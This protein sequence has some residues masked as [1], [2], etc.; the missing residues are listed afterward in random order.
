MYDVFPVFRSF[1][2]HISVLRSESSL[3]SNILS[4]F[5]DRPIDFSL[6]FYKTSPGSFVLSK[7]KA[8]S[9]IHKLIALNDHSWILF[10][11]FFSL[12][13]SDSPQ[14]T[15]GALMKR[16]SSPWSSY[17][18]L[19]FPLG[20]YFSIIGPFAAYRFHGLPRLYQLDPCLQCTLPLSVR[21]RRVE[22]FCAKHIRTFI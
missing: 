18:P 12:F 10:T 2:A 19:S 14:L 9:L 3:C 17:Q 22:I 7:Q 6:H 13:L 4:N 11:E 5:H 21:Q 15:A 8:T 1:R 16:Y 20:W